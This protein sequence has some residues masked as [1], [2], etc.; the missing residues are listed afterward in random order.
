MSQAEKYAQHCNEVYSPWFADNVMSKTTNPGPPPTARVAIITCMDARLDV[1]KMFGMGWGEAHVIRVGGGRVPDALR[2]LVASEHVLNT[3]EIMVVHHTDCGFSK[4][5]SEDVAKTE[6]KES[7][8]GL[9][10]DHIPIMPILVGPKKSVED[11][12]AFLRGCPYV[13][14]DARISGWVYETVKGTI[15]QVG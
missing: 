12:L 15:E 4:A 5:K 10:V 3:N 2:S 11:D 9:S 6:M 13:R 1:F 8:G 7:L 14:K